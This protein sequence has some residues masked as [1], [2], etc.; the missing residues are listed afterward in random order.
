ML[1]KVDVVATVEGGGMSGQAG[2]IRHG[3][4]MCLRPFV[5]V[6]TMERMRLGSTESVMS[7]IFK[8]ICTQYFISWTTFV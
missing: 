2:A 6:E 1:G 4:S 3:I 7:G 8:F 5:D